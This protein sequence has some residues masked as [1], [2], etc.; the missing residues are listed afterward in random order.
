[1]N[2]SFFSLNWYDFVKGLIVA[3]LTVF[4]ATLGQTLEMGQ[5]PTLEMIK[6][7]AIAGATAGIA[8]IIKNLLSNEEGRFLNK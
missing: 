3:V 6:T 8:Y 5:L 1:M 4:L 7:A 2:S